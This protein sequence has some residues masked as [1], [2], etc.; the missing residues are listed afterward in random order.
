MGGGTQDGICELGRRGPQHQSF[1]HL[2]TRLCGHSA[3]RLVGGSRGVRI[4]SGLQIWRF[5]N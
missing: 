3:D 2:G 4:V 5:G 1:G